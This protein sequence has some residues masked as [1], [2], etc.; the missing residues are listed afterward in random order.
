MQHQVKMQFTLASPFTREPFYQKKNPKPYQ[1]PPLRYLPK[2]PHTLSPPPAPEIPNVV[3][4][5]WGRA[6]H[7]NSRGHTEG[8]K[9]I[10][11]T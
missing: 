10:T 8:W 3:T 2:K 11:P 5:E 7:P 6:H 9:S 1:N 4:N